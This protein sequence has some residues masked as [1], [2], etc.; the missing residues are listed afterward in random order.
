MGHRDIMF[1]VAERF[2]RYRLDH[3]NWSRAHLAEKSGVTESTIKRFEK[4]GQITIENLLLLAVAMDAQEA[5]LQLFC[6]P[7]VK[8]IAQLEQH[9]HRRRRGT[10]K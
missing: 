3:L 4:T 7:E 1:A 6:L 9:S 10:N 8:S 2:Q 5:F